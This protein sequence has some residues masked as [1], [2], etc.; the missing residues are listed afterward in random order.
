MGFPELFWGLALP[1]NGEVRG[2]KRTLRSCQA[3]MPSSAVSADRSRPK[4]RSSRSVPVPGVLVEKWH[5]VL[6]NEKKKL[7]WGKGRRIEPLQK[8]KGRVCCRESRLKSLEKDLSNSTSDWGG[9]EGC[10]QAGCHQALQESKA[11][12]CLSMGKKIKAKCIRLVTNN[13]SS[14]F[15]ATFTV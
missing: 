14:Y 3:R 12:S 9:R 1:V 4:N 8:K 5:D 15:I 6:R 13:R 11:T 2:F 7:R 10:S